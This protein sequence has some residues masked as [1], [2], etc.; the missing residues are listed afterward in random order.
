MFNLVVVLIV[1]ICLFALISSIYFIRKQQNKA[2][3]KSASMAAVRHPV[4]ANPIVIAY[5][6]FPVVVIIGAIL[7][8]IF[9]R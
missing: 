7:W 4:I 8:A 2:L 9:I 3:D 6:V 1:A 5:F